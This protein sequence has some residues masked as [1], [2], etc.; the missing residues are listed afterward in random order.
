VGSEGQ[1]LSLTKPP[2]IIV[3]G[4]VLSEFDV[5][6]VLVLVLELFESGE[7]CFSQ[8]AGYKSAL[9]QHICSAI[10]QR[11]KYYLS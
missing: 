6:F 8:Y 3:K 4:R 7:M 9:T 11:E 1:Y 5:S 2:L 10:A